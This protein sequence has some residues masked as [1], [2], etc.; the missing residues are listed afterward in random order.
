M[1]S[2]VRSPFRTHPFHRFSV[3]SEVD[4]TLQQK[5]DAQDTRTVQLNEFDEKLKSI[6]G[7]IDAV[8]VQMNKVSC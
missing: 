1:R 6:T 3:L 4:Q 7:I 2:F 8:Q 5:F